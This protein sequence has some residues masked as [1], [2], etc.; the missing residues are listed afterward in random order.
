MAFGGYDGQIKIDTSVNSKNFNNSMVNIR[1]NAMLA[2]N[3][4]LISVAK[5]GW[6]IRGVFESIGKII[7]NVLV[8]GMVLFALSAKAIFRSLRDSVQEIINIRGGKTQEA[9]DNLKYSLTELKMSLAVAFLPLIE[10]AIPYIQMAINWLIKFANTVSMYIGAWYGQ[11]EVMQIVAG[12]AK[13]AADNAA[14]LA[15]NTKDAKKE[16]LGALGAFD[17]IN[18]LSKPTTATDLQ[19][20]TDTAGSIET[21]MVPITNEILNKTALIKKALLGAAD[22]LK[23][24][25]DDAMKGWGMLFD[26]LKLKWDNAIKGWGALWDWLKLK[27]DNAMKGW[28]M[29]W[30]FLVNKWNEDLVRWG[31]FW[32]WLKE[33]VGLIWGQF[34]TWATNAWQGIVDKWNAFGVWFETNVTEPIKEKFRLMWES[35]TQFASNTW[36]GIKLKWNIAKEWIKTT[37]TDPIKNFFSEVWKNISNDASNAWEK[38]KTAFKD[39]GNWFQTNVGDKIKNAFNIALDW[40]KNKWETIFSGIGEFVKGI[41]NHLIDL[42][43]GML[44]GVVVGINGLIDTANRMGEIVPGWAPISY[45]YAPQIPHLATGAVI[46]PNAAFAAIL[47]DQKS[48]KNIEAPEGLIRQIVSEEVGNIKA[49]I[50][51]NFAGNL[52]SLVRE[53]KPYIDKENVRVGGSLVKSGTII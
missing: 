18:V 15:K 4:V 13:K 21:K 9:F 25:W 50:T 53:L 49:E 7:K 16:A 2:M 45:V 8:G 3:G 33:K 17:Q 34:I 12:S 11:T 48:G 5:V 28:G 20:S 27:W 35:I 37:V 26:W 31:L 24:K 1:N 36:E 38:I 44:D 46:P 22:E 19:S 52:A 42:L 47:G 23:K 40:I 14:A 29:L 39:A 41:V 6:G 30:D 43:N 51:V 32:D 10:V